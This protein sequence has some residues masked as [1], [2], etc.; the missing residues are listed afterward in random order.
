MSDRSDDVPRPAGS[1]NHSLDRIDRVQAHRHDHASGCAGQSVGLENAQRNQQSSRW[2][3]DRS[4]SPISKARST[5]YIHIYIY[6]RLALQPRWSPADA[7]AATPRGSKQAL[8]VE[9][10]RAARS[11][12]HDIL[13]VVDDALSFAFRSF[14]C[15]FCCKRIHFFKKKTL[16]GIESRLHACI[17]DDSLTHP[18]R[19]T[20]LHCA[21]LHHG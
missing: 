3:Q 2:K 16:H 18:P 4:R 17:D 9:R 7:P 13:V 1:L 15:C 20:A 14:F 12:L 5:A 8:S 6:M 19:S 21:P 11:R 10:R